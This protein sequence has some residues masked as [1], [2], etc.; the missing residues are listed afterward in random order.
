MTYS[1]C[2]FSPC[3]FPLCS[4]FRSHSTYLETLLAVTG[5]VHLGLRLLVNWTPH[6]TSLAHIPPTPKSW[7]PGFLT[8]NYT[9][10]KMASRTWLTRSSTTLLPSTSL[11]PVSWK[12][13]SIVAREA[14]RMLWS[15]C[16]FTPLHS[17]TGSVG[18]PFASHQ[19][20]QRFAPGY[21]ST[22]LELGSPVS[23]VS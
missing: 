3:W 12:C 4:S 7:P 8:S 10:I 6:F 22:H 20:G 2:S 16:I 19:G 1:P 9:F 5:S 18:Q 17:L 23:A 14:F 13:C 15:S 21:A 11:L